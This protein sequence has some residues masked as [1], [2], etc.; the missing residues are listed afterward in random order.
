MYFSF[1]PRMLYWI[2]DGKGRFSSVKK[3][4]PLYFYVIMP[5]TGISNQV[6]TPLCKFVTPL[7]TLAGHVKSACYNLEKGV[8]YLQSGVLQVLRYNG[9]K[10]VICIDFQDVPKLLSGKT[11]GRAIKPG[12]CSFGTRL[13]CQHE[14]DEYPEHLLKPQGR[15]AYAR[16]ERLRAYAIRPCNNVTRH[17]NVDGALAGDLQSSVPVLCRG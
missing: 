16:H 17:F 1:F 11:Y 9:I 13:L 12:F 15:I 14:N 2:S 8:M 10:N 4:E 7:M 5:G 6:T 3:T